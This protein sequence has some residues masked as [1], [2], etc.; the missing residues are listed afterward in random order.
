M[1][2]FGRLAFVSTLAT[3][4]LIFVGGLVRVAGA[5]LGCPDWPK[6][7]GRWIPPLTRMQIPAGID[8]ASF[9]LTLAWIEYVN[10]LIGVT[11]GLLIAI[12]AVVALLRVRHVPRLL[13]PTLAAAVLVAFQG[14]QGSQVVATELEPLVVSVHLF[15]ALVIASLLTYV[16]QEAYYLN[17]SVS[18][19]PPVQAG[20]TRTWVGLLWLIA[21]LQ[22][23]LGA[24]V[25][26]SAET[27]IAQFPL[28]APAE[29]LSRTGGL[30]TLH[31]ALGI[32]VAVFAVYVAVSLVKTGAAQSLLVRGSAVGMAAVSLAQILL[33]LS[34]YVFGLT[35]MLQLFHVWASAL[36]VG[37]VLVVYSALRRPQERLAEHAPR[38]GRLVLGTIGLVLL[39]ALVGFGVVR[40]A[41]AARSRIPVIKPVPDFTFVDQEGRRFGSEQLKGKLTVLDF[42]FTSCRSVCPGMSAAMH[43]LYTLYAHSD[44]VQF[45]SVSVDPYTDS[46][47]RLREYAAQLGVTDDRWRFLWA[48]MGLV[49]W[50][51]R[52]G[53][54]VSDDL[55]GLHSTKFILIDAAGRVRGYYEYSDPAAQERL[56]QHIRALARELP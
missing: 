15:L 54:M 25:R 46:L 1:T 36:F 37:L 24:R 33:G 56:K 12:T 31:M 20:R 52:E 55:P 2:L 27:I 50:L 7:F 35:P 4:L 28:L 9:N 3:Y 40:Q 21:V 23:I 47:P 39:L 22:V 5:G 38:M 10:R 30:H 8:A 17:R 44:K 34:M 14:W 53:F 42:F 6:C 32:L 43:E 51:A 26:G 19:P 13:Y 49:K 16:T 29:I 45:V 18:G 41:E 11:V 48:E